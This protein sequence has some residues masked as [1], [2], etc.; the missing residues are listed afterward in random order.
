MIFALVGKSGAGKSSFGKLLASELDIPYVKTGK[1]CRTISK[2]LFGTESK[3]DTQALDDALRTID[4][5]IFLKATL[6]ESIALKGGI[7]DSLRFYSDY[8]LVKS[9]ECI[10]IRVT[11]N[12]E[13]RR[14]RLKGRGRALTNI[15]EEHCSETDL[16]MVNVDFEYD[17]SGD[18]EELHKNVLKIVQKYNEK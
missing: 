1:V 6:R 5:S 11:C 13:V 17:N 2:I 10:V 12:D 7:I 8:E 9:M 14:N 16:D 15:N 18:S 3:D 4:Q